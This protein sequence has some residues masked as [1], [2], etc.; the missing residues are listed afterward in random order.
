MTTGDIAIVSFPYADL[1]SFKARPAVIVNVIEDN[2]NDVIICLIT[3]IVSASLSTYQILLK[4]DNINNLK[5]ASLIKVSRIATVER[6]KIKAV[7]GRL[8]NQQLNVF[9]L[10]FKSLVDR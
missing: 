3:S 9:K 2:Y 4:P 1:I 8:S 5:T 10:V 7:I 6:D